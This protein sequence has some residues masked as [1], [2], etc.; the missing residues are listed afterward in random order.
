MFDYSDILESDE[1]LLLIDGTL[2]GDPWMID[3]LMYFWMIDSSTILLDWYDPRVK[4]YL[5]NFWMID[6][7][8]I[9]GLA[10][11]PP[12]TGFFSKKKVPNF[13]AL[14]FHAQ[15]TDFARTGLFEKI[16]F[17]SIFG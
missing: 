17:S 10:H 11:S 2:W 15:W 13:G 8:K 7:S 4:C 3:F 6:R 5:M 12:E 1:Y 14:K 16:Y 9:K